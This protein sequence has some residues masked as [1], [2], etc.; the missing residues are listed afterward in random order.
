MLIDVVQ[1]LK[2]IHTMGYVLHNL[3]PS[4]IWVGT[5]PVEA[6]LADFSK[7]IPRTEN[8]ICYDTANIDNFTNPNEVPGGSIR[9]DL[10]AFGAILVQ[11]QVGNEKMKTLTDPHRVLREARWLTYK[12]DDTENL[13]ALFELTLW[14]KEEYSKDPHDAILKALKKFRLD[15]FFFKGMD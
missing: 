8:K 10:W 15:P 14:Q 6:V 12:C 1:G 7:V 9:H 3:R 5:K 13:K 2:E 11:V 4:N